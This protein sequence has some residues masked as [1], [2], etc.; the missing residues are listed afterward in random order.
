[1]SKRF[2]PAARTVV[3]QGA[4]QRSSRMKLYI[5]ETDAPFYRTA[6][7][8]QEFL[9]FRR[10]FNVPVAARVSSNSDSFFGKLGAFLGLR[11][12]GIISEKIP[13]KGSLEQAIKSID[14]MT[15]S[16]NLKVK[17]NASLGSENQMLADAMKP[18]F[19]RGAVSFSCEPAESFLFACPNGAAD[20]DGMGI[21]DEKGGFPSPSISTKVCESRWMSGVRRTRRSAQFGRLKRR[22]NNWRMVGLLESH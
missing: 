22:G 16:S 11:P 15:V 20:I 14:V 3:F 5:K 18:A 12:I 8:I 13:L 7:G 6:P 17:G 9:F 2:H 10:I 19:Q 4:A 1:M 21:D